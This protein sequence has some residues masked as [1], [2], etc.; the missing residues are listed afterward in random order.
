MKKKNPLRMVSCYPQR[1]PQPFYCLKEEEREPWREE[2]AKVFNISTS[3]MELKV[4]KKS[5]KIT[6]EMFIQGPKLG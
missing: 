6:A 5:L 4:P 1:F 3:C 2:L